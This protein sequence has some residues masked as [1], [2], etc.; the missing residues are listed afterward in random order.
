[1]KTCGF[2]D[3]DSGAPASEAQD[4]GAGLDQTALQ[5]AFT[6]VELLVVI[7]IIT[8]LIALLLPALSVAREASRRTVCASNLRQLTMSTM[9]LA[10]ED[11]G[12]WPDLHNTRW[13]WNPVDERYIQ[14]GGYW[15]G[16]SHMPDRPSDYYP[17]NMNYQPSTF[18]IN[19]LNALIGHEWQYVAGSRTVYGIAYCPSQPDLN[20]PSSWHTNTYGIFSGIGSIWS[21]GCTLGYNYFPGTYSWYFGG[22]YIN[23]FTQANP[24]TLHQ[25]TIPMFPRFSVPTPTFSMKM[26]DKPQ[27]RVIW[28]DRV[29]AKAPNNQAG[30][31]VSA[32]NHMS[33][34]EA[35][36]G[37]IGPAVK[38]GANV[39][40][41]DGHVEWKNASDFIVPNQYSWI[42][43]PAGG[44]EITQFAPPD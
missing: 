33:G 31:M 22:W 15:P 13:G 39:S 7:G 4:Y 12:W 27:H 18:A 40:Y 30:D 38:G 29:G 5:G 3:S 16:S 36:R 41:G 42:Y 21:A 14:A 6:I 35:A 23:G 10:M 28:S 2:T 11:H 8:I 32:S 25:P 43:V 20:K 34:M 9:R 24:N 26:G 37:R 19:A 1:M 17:D 44:T